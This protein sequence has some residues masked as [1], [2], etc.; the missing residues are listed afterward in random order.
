MHTTSV[1]KF[2]S[3]MCFLILSVSHGK[4][5]FTTLLQDCAS[6]PTG[7]DLS[8]PATCTHEEADNRMMLNDTA[9]YEGHRQV[10][11]HTSDTDFGV[12]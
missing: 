8:S 2:F 5:I 9:V 3:T 11:V 1:S 6:N 7:A 4:Q 12:L 10:L